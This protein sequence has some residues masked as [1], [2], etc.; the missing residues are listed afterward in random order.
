MSNKEEEGEGTNLLMLRFRRL[1]AAT[2][3]TIPHVTARDSLVGTDEE[4]TDN[5]HPGPLRKR[6]LSLIWVACQNARIS[7]DTSCCLP[8]GG[9]SQSNGVRHF[10][11]PLAFAGGG[12]AC[13]TEVHCTEEGAGQAA[14]GAGAGGTLPPGPAPGRPAG[15]LLNCTESTSEPH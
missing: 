5:S 12:A 6:A 9:E 1:I 11:T 14:G 4:I 10:F 2:R 8:L 13:F 3:L 15:A 7:R